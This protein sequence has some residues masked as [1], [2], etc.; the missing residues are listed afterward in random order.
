[1]RELR[2]LITSFLP[3]IAGCDHVELFSTTYFLSTR[4][5]E[6]L[7][8]AVRLAEISFLYADPGKDPVTVKELVTPALKIMKKE[9]LPPAGEDHDRSMRCVRE[10]TT[11]AQRHGGNKPG[12]ITFPQ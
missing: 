8:D 5:A 9:K 12:V 4:K 1:M 7:D 10:A 11:E 2:S 3:E 6:S